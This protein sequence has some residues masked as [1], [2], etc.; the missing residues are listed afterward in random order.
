M[1]MLYNIRSYD[2]YN[3]NDDNINDNI[4]DDHIDN[5]DIVLMMTLMTTIKVTRFSL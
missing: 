4:D 1:E 3:L 2:D 5:N